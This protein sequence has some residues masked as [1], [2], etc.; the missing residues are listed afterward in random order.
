MRRLLFVLALVLTPLMATGAAAQTTT[1]DAMDVPGN[2]TDF[3]NRGTPQEIVVITGGAHLVCSGG[4]VIRAQQATVSRASQTINLFQNVRVDDPAH[5]LQADQATFFSQTRRLSATGSVV[6]TDRNTGSIIRGDQLEY[7]QQTPERPQSRIETTVRSGL[8]RAILFRAAGT[9][10]VPGAARDSTIVDALQ[11]TIIGEET[12]RAIGQAVMTRDSMVATGYTIGYEQDTGTMSVAGGGRVQLPRQE[13]R[14]DSIDARVGADDELEEVLTRHGAH[15]ISEEMQVRAPAI[16]LMFE[17][18]GVSRMVA[19]GW[20]AVQGVAPGPRPRVEAEEFVMES[21]SID[22]LAPGQQITEV[23][24]IGDAFGERITPDSLL[25][26]L[27][28]GTPEQLALISTDW[29][30]GDTVRAYFGPADGTPESGRGVAADTAGVDP[31]AA[32]TAAAAVAPADARPATGA[33]PAGERVMERL[34]ASGSPAR[35]VYRMRDENAPEAKLSIN[36]LTAS[37]IDVRFANGTVAV[38]SAEGDATGI[39]LQPGA[40]APRRSGTG[41]TGGSGTTGGAPPAGGR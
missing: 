16:R 10:A 14:G 29:M 31:V 36:Y 5:T 37:R 3:L 34:T 8:A 30:R 28:E 15:L 24:A 9:G 13:L 12:F 7:Y 18:G 11:I 22:A 20:P 38:V 25:A 39:Y 27:P 6:V 35:S 21:D 26:L 41:G 33:E 19:M 32:D 23:V 40:P 2:Q 1:C 17:G 4:R